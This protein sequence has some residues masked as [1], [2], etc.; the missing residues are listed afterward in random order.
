MST[1]AYLVTAVT[2]SDS[3]DLP[4]GVC[5]CLF[6]GVGGDVA[7]F[8]PG[9]TTS[10]VHR[11]VSAGSVLLTQA[12]RVLVTGTTATSIVAWYA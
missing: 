10:V 5:T 11:G 8:S 3:V 6:I 12:R 4:Q 9:T 1:T 2:P 7:I